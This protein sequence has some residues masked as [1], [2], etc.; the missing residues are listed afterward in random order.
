MWLA[1]CNLLVLSQ[2][3]S[4]PGDLDPTFGSG[5]KVT[6]AIGSSHDV[7][8]SVALQSDGKI[9][10]AGY[11]GTHPNRDFALVRYTAAGA[12]DAGFGSGGKVTT[13]I[14]SSDDAGLSVALQSDGKIVV[15]GISNNSSDDD[16]ALVRYTT[17]GTLD[18]SFGSAGKVTTPVGSAD[19]RGASV[20]LQSDGKIVVAGVSRMVG[21]DD[22]ALVRYTAEGALDASFGSGGKVTTDF[23]SSDDSG[24]SVALQSDGKIVVAGYSYNGSKFD[25]ALV[26]YTAAGALD[27]SFGNGGK[28]TTPIGN[29]YDVAYSVAVQSDGKIVV[30]GYSTIGGNE[31]FALVR[32]TAEGAL[33]AGF[34]SGGKVT[35]PIGGGEDIGRSVALQSDGKIVVAGYSV[36]GTNPNIA[37]LRYTAAGAPDTSFGSNGK[38]T[39]AIGFGEDIGYSVAVQSDGKIV[40][41]GGPPTSAT[42]I[43]RWRATRGA[44]WRRCRIGG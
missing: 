2:A 24:W 44:G 1:A 26:R 33:D 19:D 22:F 30:A 28:V 18:A 43:L 16:F 15:A 14:G 12:L 27:A 37:L 9:V 42:T 34:G 29:S 4:A 39:T 10:V 36:F 6:T 17:E 40:V 31:D 41:A 35:T 3:F 8:S 32:Y 13:P 21:N 25:F 7:G 23:G 5:G 38:V 11:S 20:A